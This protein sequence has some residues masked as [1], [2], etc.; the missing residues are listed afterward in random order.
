M[1]MPIPIKD[2]WVLIY[3]IDKITWIDS[4]KKK[5]KYTF[6]KY[7]A[8]EVSLWNSL[9]LLEFLL[10]ISISSAACRDVLSHNWMYSV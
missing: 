3:H 4:K 9:L 6:L 10:H 2:Q 7:E 8:L 5:L 1:H